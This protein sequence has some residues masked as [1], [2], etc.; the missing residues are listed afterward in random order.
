M[1]DSFCAGTRTIQDRTSVNIGHC[2][3]GAISLTEWRV[4]YRIGVH[5]I[6]DRGINIFANFH[7]K[8]DCTDRIA[9]R[10]GSRG[11]LL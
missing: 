9:F 2:D 11:Y 5:A 4:T 10:I 6:P 3:L 1:P 8:S 7:K